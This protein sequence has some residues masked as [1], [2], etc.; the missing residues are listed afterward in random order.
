M[1]AGKRIY[2]QISW[3]LSIDGEK[4]PLLQKSKYRNSGYHGL[5]WW[6]AHDPITLPAVVDVHFQTTGEQPTIGGEPLVLW[7]ETGTRIPWNK[8]VKS[9]IHLRSADNPDR[10]F[11][12]HHEQ[13]WGNHLVYEPYQGMFR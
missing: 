7:S 13:L 9:T 11:D 12:T 10:D 8:S 3:S 4:V 5:A 6:I 1:R 2:D